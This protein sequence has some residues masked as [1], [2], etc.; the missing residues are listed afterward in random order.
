MMLPVQFIMESKADGVKKKPI[1]DINIKPTKT[2]K[3]NI[4]QCQLAAGGIIPKHPFRMLFSGASGSGKTTVM[5]D[6]LKRFYVKDITKPD[7]GS[8]FDTIHVIGPTVKIDDMYDDLKI[9]DTNKHTEFNSDTLELIHSKQKSAIETKGVDKSKKICTVIEDSIAETRFMNSKEFLNQ[10]VMN[11]HLNESTMMMSQAYNKVP[12]ACR[13]NC[14]QIVFFP[15]S[16]SE[17]ERIVD[18][19][20]PPGC[21]KDDFRNLVMQATK[22]DDIDK[23]PFLFIDTSEPVERR[24]RRCLHTYLLPRISYEPDKKKRRSRK[25]TRDPIDEENP[26]LKKPKKTQLIKK[27]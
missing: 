17:V 4:P 23:Y 1:F 3:H 21:T 18:E 13:I 5:L 19:F 16:N 20:I 6:M 26:D 7:K 24:Y 27:K 9:P 10:F 15:S 12:R 22:V 25:R 2:K 11:R 8:Y 14:T